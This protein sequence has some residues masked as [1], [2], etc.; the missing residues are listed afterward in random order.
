LT[1][2][3]RN[4]IIIIGIINLLFCTYYLW[5]TLKLEKVFRMEIDTITKFGKRIGFVTL[6]YLPN[7]F[8]FT[9]FFLENST[10]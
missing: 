9:T 4:F 6:L 5:E 3:E 8:L 10:I 7:V 1:F 2:Q